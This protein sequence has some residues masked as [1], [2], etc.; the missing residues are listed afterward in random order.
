MMPPIGKPNATGR[1][2]GKW[3]SK[4]KKLFGPP[5]DTPWTWQTLE[6]MCSP[7]WRAMSINTRRLVDFLQVEHRH[8]AGLENGN[9]KATYDDLVVHGLTRSKIRSAIEEAKFLGLIRFKRGGRW[10]GTNR[11]SE[12][13]LTFYADKDRN[14]PTNQ[15]KDKTQEVIDEWIID[16]ERRRRVCNTP[17]EKQIPG[18][19]SR[20]TVV[21]LRELRNRSD[22][23][24]R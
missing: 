24:R 2:S 4:D 8:H 11:P 20:T 9:L 14:P 10:A 22:G 18:A 1:S 5:K 23:K 3:T 6:L 19:T 16:R 21:P 7:A 17:R 15:W 13:R 12:F